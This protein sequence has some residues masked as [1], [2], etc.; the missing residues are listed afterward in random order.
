MY[1][2]MSKKKKVKLN[3]GVPRRGR[4]VTSQ[5]CLIIENCLEEVIFLRDEGEQPF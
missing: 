3:V 5:I 2:I 4:G 1:K